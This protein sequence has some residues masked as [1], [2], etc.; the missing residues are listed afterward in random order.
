MTNDVAGNLYLLWN[1]G[2]VDKGPERIFYS[3]STDGVN[4]SPKLDVSLAPAGVPQARISSIV[5]TPAVY[6][7]PSAPR[8]RA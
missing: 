6:C 1:A 4:W 2:N 8:L 7:L 3:T 5:G